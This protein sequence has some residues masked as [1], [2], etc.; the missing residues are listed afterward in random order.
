MRHRRPNS[1]II[2]HKKPMT[3]ILIFH[4]NLR[5]F[6]EKKK[7][8]MKHVSSRQTTP[9][10]CGVVARFLPHWSAKLK[11]SHTN[12]PPWHTPRSPW[13]RPKLL[14]YHPRSSAALDYFLL[15]RNCR[16]RE[17]TISARV[18]VKISRP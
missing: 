8:R 17:L 3:E 15:V 4:E 13:Q 12:P 11:P 18:G 1:K 6:P 14:H 2:S 7:L 9:G 10:V 5:A 16:R